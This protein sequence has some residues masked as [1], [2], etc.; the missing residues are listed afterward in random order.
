[1]HLLTLL[2][3]SQIHGYLLVIKGNILK[4]RLERRTFLLLKSICFDH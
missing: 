3:R 2:E 4:S 1:M